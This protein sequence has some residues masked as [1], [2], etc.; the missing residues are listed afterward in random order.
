MITILSFQQVRFEDPETGVWRIE[1]ATGKEEE[2]EEEEEQEAALPIAPLGADVEEEG[3]GRKRG[4]RG[5]EGRS[6][7]SSG[8]RG[9]WCVYDVALVGVVAT[10]QHPLWTR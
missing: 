5:E 2:E 6:F 3:G 7:S 8:G 1:A 4:Q 10:C 9:G